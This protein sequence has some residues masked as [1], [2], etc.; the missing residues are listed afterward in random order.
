MRDSEIAYGIDGRKVTYKSGERTSLDTKRLKKER[1]ELYKK[2]AVTKPTRTFKVSAKKE[3][4][5]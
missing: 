4:E 5:E 1:P 3:T 2:Y